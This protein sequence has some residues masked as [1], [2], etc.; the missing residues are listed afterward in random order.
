MRVA[1][2]FTLTR[3]WKQCVRDKG[4]FQSRASGF[5][6]L[7][8]IRSGPG[9][10]KVL[11]DPGGMNHVFIPGLNICITSLLEASDSVVVG[12]NVDKVKS[13]PGDQIPQ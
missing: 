12:S 9:C 2:A 8:V 13:G 10:H 3:C 5:L 7:G 1:C 6:Y 11:S 4:E